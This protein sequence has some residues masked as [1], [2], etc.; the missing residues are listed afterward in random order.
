MAEND[1]SPTIDDAARPGAWPAMS[2]ADVQALLCA[3]GTPFEMETVT[4][5]G[6]PTRCWKNQPPSLATLARLARTNFGG[7]TFLVYEDERV[8]YEGW[9]RA[10]AALAAELARL[11]IGKGDRVAL[12]MRNL[13]EWPVILFAVTSLGAIVVPLNA[14]WTG[15]EL[16][17]GLEHAGAK[18]LICDSQRWQRIEPHL[19]ELPALRQAIVSR[20]DGAL[21]GSAM[22][23]ESI[24]GAPGGYGDLPDIDLPAIEIAPDDDATLFYTSGT[25]GRPKGALGTHRNILTCLISASYANQRSALR[26]GEAPVPPEPKVGLI[27]IPMFHVTACNAFLMAT[28]ATGSTI[29]FMRKWDT[30]AA[31]AL[32]EKE[33][34]TAT[35]GVPAIAWQLLEHPDRDKY[36]LSSLESIA[37]G[38]APS[39]PE[40]VRRIESDLHAL[41]SNG[42]GMTETSATVTTHSAEDYLHRPD[43]CGPPLPV[44]DLRIM[45]E[46]GSREMPTGEVGELWARGPQ[47]VKGYW[48]DPAATAATFVDGWVRT[49]DIARLDAE[50]FCFIVDRAKDVIIR[51]GENIYSSEVE[52]VLYDHP[53]VTDA[54]LVGVPHRTLGEVPAAVVHCAPGTT[55]SEADL[56]DWVGVRLAAFK[57][58]VRILFRAETLPR[59][60]NGK[61]LK[62]ELRG[63]FGGYE[64]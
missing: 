40:L 43:S 60:A 11:G 9:F 38:G 21:A 3:P 1:V 31:F 34:V 18:L 59:N 19:A 23:L 52:F 48:N 33:R 44:C 42:W 14:W 39:A 8:S 2:L 57:V 29:I 10:T 4:I 28:I 46:D 6:V 47:I 13:P 36:D 7:S 51:G 45:S 16:S 63:L 62:A 35:G 49:G 54:A 56:Q 20:A 25:T 55:V 58:P 26:R 30:V 27:V 24:I 64:G 22:S 53:A 37:Y 5:G 12:A 61:I 32:I 15:A 17:F 50:G 41:P